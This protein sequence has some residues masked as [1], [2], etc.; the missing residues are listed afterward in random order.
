MFLMS[1]EFSVDT[2]YRGRFRKRTPGREKGEGVYGRL[3]EPAQLTINIGKIENVT[4]S[5]YFLFVLDND[6]N[7][8]QITAQCTLRYID[9][10]NND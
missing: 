4:V 6:D 9:S 7:C 3:R 5:N 10:N 1:S 2:I 8:I